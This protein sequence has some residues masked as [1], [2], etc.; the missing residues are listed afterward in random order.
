MAIPKRTGLV[1]PVVLWG[2]KI[3]KNKIC[4]ISCLCNGRIIITGTVDGQIL[5]WIV[6]E[7]LGW[8][9]PQMMLL[10]HDCEITCISP[11][12]SLSTYYFLIFI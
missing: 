4:Q 3:P 7:T 12:S 10:V 1:I 11:T 8:I 2:S 6:D 9:Q 5:Q